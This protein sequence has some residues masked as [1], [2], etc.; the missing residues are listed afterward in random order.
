MHKAPL[1]EVYGQSPGM[2]WALTVLMCSAS[3]LVC[4][5]QPAVGSPQKMT[6]EQGTLFEDASKAQ[7]RKVLT[8]DAAALDIQRVWRGF[9]IRRWSASR[10][11]LLHESQ[12]APIGRGAV[13]KNTA[14]PTHWRWARRF[15]VAHETSV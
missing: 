2:A 3:W 9:S 12:C 7:G 15:E 11:V 13:Q 14:Q 5:L 8:T 4:R 1:P 6:I 10:L